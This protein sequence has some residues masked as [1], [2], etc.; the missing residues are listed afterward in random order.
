MNVLIN[1][2]YHIK[3]Q[4]LI[5]GGLVAFGLGGLLRWTT[6]FE[7]DIVENI[8]DISYRDFVKEVKTGDLILTSS[9]ELTSITRMFTNSLW[10]HCGI[11][12][13]GDDGKLYEW[14]AHSE[15]EHVLNS[16][17]EFDCSGAQLVPVEYLAALNGSVFW[18]RV[19]MKESQRSYVKKAIDAIAYKIRFS[20]LTEFMVYLGSPFAALF[21]GVGGGMACSHVVAATYIGA[22]VMDIDRKLSQYTPKSFSDIG[23]A[24]WKVNTAPI[25]MVVGYDAT[26]LVRLQNSPVRLRKK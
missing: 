3:M 16:R 10:S 9:T 8:D 22:G 15:T 25:K 14:S 12:Y 24:L 26:T 6:H 19:D 20:T 21:D 11:A 4:A 2:H 13:W 5:S 18:R 7:D 23:D 1:A 17:G